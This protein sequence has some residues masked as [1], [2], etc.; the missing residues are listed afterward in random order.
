[1]IKAVLFDF[2]GV[3][4]QSEP[5][6]MRTFLEILGKYKIEIPIERWYREFAAT[7]SRSIFERLSKE[8]DIKED[9]GQ[10][11]EARRALYEGYVREGALKEVP[12]VEGF[13]RSLRS[14]DM[15]TAIVSGSHRTNVELALSFF[16]LNDFFDIVV[17]ADDIPYRK[18]DPGPYL[19]TA[20]KLGIEPKD[21]AVIE[22]SVSGCESGRRAG[23]KLIV[24]R[25][26][27]LPDI[28]KYDMLIDDFRGLGIERLESF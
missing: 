21:C 8:Y 19:Y 11:V 22:D 7:E 12:G 20:K 28:G 15:K 13:L 27:A 18:P 3:V 23:M 26:P 10:L 14:T 16:G 5:L 2:D 1:M 6:H 17:S 9:I 25:S 24:M 4:V